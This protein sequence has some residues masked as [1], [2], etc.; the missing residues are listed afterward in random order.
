MGKL[1][2][3]AEAAKLLGASARTV[4]GWALAGLLPAVQIGARDWVF[5]EAAVRAFV[6]PPM[7]RPRKPKGRSRA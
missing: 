7:G 3:T 5:T 1:L 6:R 4:R 2:T